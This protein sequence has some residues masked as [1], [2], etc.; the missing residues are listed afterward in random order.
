[1]WVANAQ[2]N[3]VSEV[4]PVS[5]GVVTLVGIGSDPLSIAV[6]DRRV[7]VG[8]GTSQSIRMISPTPESVV[9]SAGTTPRSIIPVGAGVWV[10]GS[11]PGRVLS[12]T[13]PGAKPVS[14]G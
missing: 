5:L 8:F 1:V 13:A 12:V 3:T 7:F 2:S 9:L 4:D 10:A 11:N 6:A 14:K